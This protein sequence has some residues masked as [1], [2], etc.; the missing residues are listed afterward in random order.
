MSSI[1]IQTTKQ[2]FF[3]SRKLSKTFLKMLTFLIKLKLKFLNTLT[4]R[5]VSKIHF[6]KDIGSGLGGLPEIANLVT[7]QI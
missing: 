5:K 1:V 4:Q 7:L 3:T 6:N 2:H